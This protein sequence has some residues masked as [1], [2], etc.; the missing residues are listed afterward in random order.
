MISDGV[1][2]D[3]AMIQNTIDAYS[4][5]GHYEPIWPKDFYDV[6]DEYLE[7]NASLEDVKAV[8][9]KYVGKT[10][11]EVADIADDEAV[12]RV[13]AEMAREESAD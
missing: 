5:G 6:L 7:D 2:I 10:V 8:A 9:A 1:V 12:A 11:G 13:K 3:D 4:D